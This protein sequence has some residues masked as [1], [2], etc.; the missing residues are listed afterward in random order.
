MI[1]IFLP[2]AVAFLLFSVNCE[3]ERVCVCMCV[4]A[5]YHRIIAIS[6]KTIF[7]EVCLFLRYPDI[8]AMENTSVYI[9]DSM[10]HKRLFH[11][12]LRNILSC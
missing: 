6:I 12:W 11:S 3:G 1:S 4:V 7:S 2:F 5:V 10:T 8:Y 9:F